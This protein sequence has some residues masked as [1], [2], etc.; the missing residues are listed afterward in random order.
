MSPLKMIGIAVA[1]AVATPA[2][3]RDVVP[4]QFRGHWCGLESE[5]ADTGLQR[6]SR[7][8]PTAEDVD[9]NLTVTADE[10]DGTAYGRCK[11]L[12]AD[13]YR[14]RS[15]DYI[16]RLKCGDAPT[17]LYWLELHNGNLIH[18]KFRGG[19]YR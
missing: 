1:V 19:G 15:P 3:A 4:Q 8:C 17:E 11:V 12:M 9:T 16:V 7:P 6:V 13:R 18:I 14:P 5:M 10:I 2:A